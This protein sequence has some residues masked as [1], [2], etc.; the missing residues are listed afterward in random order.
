[1]NSLIRIFAIFKK[2]GTELLRDPIYLGLAIIVPLILKLIFGYGLSMDVKNI[3]VSF[4]NEDGTYLSREYMNSFFNSEYFKLYSVEKSYKNVD[5]LIRSGKIRVYIVIPY[6]FSRK[7]YAGEPSKVQVIIDGSFPSRAEVVRGYVTAINGMFTERLIS[8]FLSQAGYTGITVSPVTIENRAW[9]NPA[10]ESNNFIIPGLLVT[11]LM[12]YPALLA[13]LI[14]VREKER[15]TIFNLYC[16]PVKPFEIVLGKSTPYIFVAFFDYIIIFIMSTILFRVNFLG[17]FLFLSAS[18]FIY[19]TCTIGIGLFISTITRTQIS[20]MLITFIGTVIPAFLYSGLLN[21][22]GGLDAMG[23]FVSH[24]LPA[25]YFMG[26]VRGI[27]LKGLGFMFY[28]RDL[29]ILFIYTLIVYI[30]TTLFFKKRID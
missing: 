13:S 27:Y 25:T 26:I 11:T 15:G 17:S 9:Y 21:P 1:M 8:D 24:L 4:I 14:V 12:F 19:I 3:P 6:D 10:L 20:A 2:E 5:K 28:L 30:I 18:T 16:S 23:Q 7:L 22:V 29:I